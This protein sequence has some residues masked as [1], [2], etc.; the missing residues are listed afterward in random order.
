MFRVLVLTP[1]KKDPPSRQRR[2]CVVEALG[3]FKVE[4]LNPIPGRPPKKNK[5]FHPPLFPGMSF[6]EDASLLEKADFV[7]ADLTGADFKAGFLISE[8]LRQGK[9]VLGL[10]WGQI[11]RLKAVDWQAEKN[12]YLECVDKDN[13]RSVLRRFMNFLVRARLSRGRLIVFDGIN[14]SGKATQIKLLTKKLRARGVKY[15]QVDFPRY[16]SSFYGALVG[17]FLHNEL[18]DWAATNPCLAAVLFAADRF[19]AREQLYDWLRAGNLV[20]ANRYVSAM[21][22]QAA[23]LPVEKRSAFIDWVM[24]MEYQV[25][26]IPKEDLVVFLHLPAKT[27]EKLVGRKPGSISSKIN[28]AGS[29]EKDRQYQE[30]SEKV[31]LQLTRKFEHWVKINCADKKGKLLSPA[32]IS[33]RVVALLER[34]GIVEK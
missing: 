13:I 19:Q 23:R 33:K 6:D 8:A 26:R 12:F 22:H 7:I 27:T 34:R 3:D 31:F 4:L 24:E 2:S 11:E 20:I 16:E 28:G 18:G 9:P 10:F 32:K 17:R 30:E 21:A 14:G 29:L 15:K 25:N 5:V 1:Q